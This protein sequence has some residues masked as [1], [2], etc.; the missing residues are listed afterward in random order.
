MLRSTFTRRRSAQ[1]P[2]PMVTA[3][4]GTSFSRALRGPLQIQH[5]LVAPRGV[6][7]LG[8]HGNRDHRPRTIFIG[9]IRAT[10]DRASNFSDQNQAQGDQEIRSIFF[11]NV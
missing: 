3:R 5:A 4:T 6:C 10:G 1:N 11:Q 7:G 8:E 2:S 9:S